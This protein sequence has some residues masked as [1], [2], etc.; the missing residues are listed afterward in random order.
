ML[1]VLTKDLCSYYGYNEYL[2]NKFLHLF[3]AGS[4]VSLKLSKYMVFE[5][6]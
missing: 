5:I 1:K 6:D 4:A 3:P 2:M